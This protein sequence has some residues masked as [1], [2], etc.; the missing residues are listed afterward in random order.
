MWGSIDP[1]TEA[2]VPTKIP[3]PSKHVL[4]VHLGVNFSGVVVSQT[5]PT[6][7]EIKPLLV[8][9]KKDSRCYFNHRRGISLDIIRTIIEFA[10]NC[11]LPCLKV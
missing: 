2:T 8:G 4:S 1:S 10:W 11:N 6:F 3:F 5:L 7:E 9:W